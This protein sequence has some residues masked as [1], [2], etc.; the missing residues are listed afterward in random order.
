MTKRKTLQ[1]LTIRDNY[2]FGAV[3]TEEN[4]CRKFLEM[5]LGFPI[6]H[7]EINKE[8]CIA[9][10]PEQLSAGDCHPLL[11]VVPPADRR[12]AQMKAP[13]ERAPR[14]KYAG[15]VLEIG[16]SPGYP[17]ERRQGYPL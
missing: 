17:C 12:G 4:N 9:Y 2:M 14:G 1:E 16:G 7:L 6:S 11:K 5:T 8:K 13:S 3:M 15:G 10:H